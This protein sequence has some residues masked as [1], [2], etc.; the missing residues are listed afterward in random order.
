MRGMV[1]LVSLLGCIMN[2]SVM[3]P[4]LPL[5]LSYEDRTLVEINAASGDLFLSLDTVTGNATRANSTFAKCKQLCQKVYGELYPDYEM[6]AEEVYDNCAW[7]FYTKSEGQINGM[8]RVCFDSQHGLPVQPSLSSEIAALRACNVK[9]AEP[10]RFVIDNA[11]G[12]YAKYMKAIYQL[13]VLSD[14]DTFLLQVRNEHANFYQRCC[15]AVELDS[16]KAPPGCTNLC[17][18]IPDTDARFFRAF[19]RD[20]TQLESFCA[21]KEV[22]YENC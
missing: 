2:T 6:E 11:D 5:Q 19:G 10:G 17:W 16:S 15:G 18:S 12:L 22:G 3:A 9:I 20:Q 14:V 8:M 4:K 13:A 21:A 7:I 1:I